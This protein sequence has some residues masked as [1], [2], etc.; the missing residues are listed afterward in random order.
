MLNLKK[1]VIDYDLKKKNNLIKLNNTFLFVDT[2]FLCS[3]LL[4]TI[5]S[6]SFYLSCTKNIKIIKFFWLTKF[7]TKKNH[8]KNVKQ[9]F[10]I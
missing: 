8:Q 2:L 6:F 10:L 5:F 9:Y 1:K 4:F 3:G 7:L